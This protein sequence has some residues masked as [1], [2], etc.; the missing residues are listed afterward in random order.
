MRRLYGRSRE[1]LVD[2]LVKN[3]GEHA[4]VL[5]DNAG[6]HVTVRFEDEE[7]AVRAAAGRVQLA[8]SAQYY[9]GKAPRNEF[10]FGFSCMSERTIREAVRRIAH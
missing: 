9:I 3:F 1:T 8:S 6:M 10:I 5:G 2:G 7:L 4:Q